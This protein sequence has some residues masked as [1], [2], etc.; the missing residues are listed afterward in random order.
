MFELSSGMTMGF[1]FGLLIFIAYMLTKCRFQVQEGYLAVLEE[2]GKTEFIDESKK[3]VKTYGPGLHFKKPWQTARTVS[4]MEQMLELSG[5]E[6]GTT[7]MA[8]DGTMLRFDST[9]RFT[10]LRSQIYDYLF[11]LEQPINHVKSLFV[12]LLRNEIANFDGNSSVG[13]QEQKIA[14]TPPTMQPGSY[15]VIRRER[16]LLNRSIQDFCRDQIGD[17][18]GVNFDGVD[19]TDILPPDE[20]AEALNSVINAHSEAQSL[21]ARMEGECEQQILAAQKGLGIASARAK[22]VQEEITTMAD[23]LAEL[24]KSGTLNH[25]LER[26]RAEVFAD[27]RTSY[28]KRPT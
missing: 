19:L 9:V 13:Q 28:V 24:Q 22:A 18:Y 6:G 15:A 21:Y 4:V 27:A 25:Y 8:S 20:L 14:L 3:Q 12:C 10:P 2:F 11:A 7:A 5:A 16:R 17:R 1:S 23:I 26:R